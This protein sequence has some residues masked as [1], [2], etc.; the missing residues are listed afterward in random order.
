LLAAR[1]A[2][3][4]RPPREGE[5]ARRPA[6]SAVAG[7]AT[8]PAFTS[9]A[10][11]LGLAIGLAPIPGA[12]PWRGG[13]A[14]AWSALVAAP[15]AEEL[16]YRERVYDALRARWPA[17]P[18][19]AATSALFALPHLEPW[20]VVGAFVAGL[21]LGAL[22][23]CGA[24]AAACIGAHAGLNLASLACGAPPVRGALP[25]AAAALALACAAAAALK[26]RRRPTPSR[27]AGTS[28]GT[29]RPGRRA[30]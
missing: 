23:A 1:H 4:P 28:A 24:P 3:A 21:G 14:L 18:T 17:A 25:P 9:C 6:A 20:P 19:V 29:A 11:V 8:F 5:R 27:T 22:R 7:Y 10:I 30:R 2:R 12:P 16:L 13:A 26:L 15:I